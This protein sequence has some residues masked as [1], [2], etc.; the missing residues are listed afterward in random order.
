MGALLRE[1][2]AGGVTSS[3]KKSSGNPVLVVPYLP[4]GPGPHP[5][6]VSLLSEPLCSFLWPSVA[7]GCKGGGA[8]GGPGG[9]PVLLPWLPH[10]AALRPFGTAG[11]RSANPAS[12]APD[13]TL[14]VCLP[15][16]E[17]SSLEAVRPENQAWKMHWRGPAENGAGAQAGHKATVTLWEGPVQALSPA[18]GSRC[19]WHQGCNNFLAA[20]GFFYSLSGFR[21][22]VAN[23]KKAV[24]A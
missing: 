13:R 17:R 19:H 5:S 1:P 11:F 6:P 23:G 14:V 3:C 8:A 20:T 7:W 4:R 16:Q 9:W 21:F 15:G 10:Q 12:Q 18:P 2:L 24:F 22:T